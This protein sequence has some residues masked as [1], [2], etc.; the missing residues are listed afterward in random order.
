MKLKAFIKGE[1][2]LYEPL[3]GLKTSV[4]STPPDGLDRS[5]LGIDDSSI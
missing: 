1:P 5:A 2:A 3:L 4:K